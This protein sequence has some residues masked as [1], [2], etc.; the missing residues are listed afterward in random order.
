MSAVPCIGLVFGIAGL[1]Q[2]P[3]LQN[4]A[5]YHDIP[6]IPR[7][8]RK[9]FHHIPQVALASI[10]VGVGFSSFFFFWI[11]TVS[12]SSVEDE[13]IKISKT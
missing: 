13:S 6:V 12:T 2:E 7:A 1:I 3:A 9:L 4:Y 11:N 10:G 5:E 8:V